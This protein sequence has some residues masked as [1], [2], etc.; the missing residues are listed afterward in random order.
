[1]DG[2]PIDIRAELTRQLEN[3]NAL[4]D[5]SLSPTQVVNLAEARRRVTDSLAK[6]QPTSAAAPVKVREV[7]GLEDMFYVMHTV[8]ERHPAVRDEIAEALAAHRENLAGTSLAL[9]EIE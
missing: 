8:L 4:D 7:E 1:V 2:E 3:L 9:K 6:V 5:G